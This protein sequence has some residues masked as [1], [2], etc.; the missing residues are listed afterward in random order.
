MISILPAAPAD[1]A[2]LAELLLEMDKFYG[3]SSIESV[4]A[5]I[6]G[7]NSALF[8]DPP[9]AYALLAWQE[10]TL[11][12]FVGYSFL[13]P[14]AL[15]ARSL[16]LKELYVSQAHQRAGVGR[17]LMTRLFEVAAENKCSRV[18]WT[19]DRDNLAAQSF[20]QRLALPVN[21]S[22]LFYRAEGYVLNTLG[23]IGD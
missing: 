10:S 5:K 18:E 1:A 15:S 7:I 22:K 20:Y 13:W 2:P 11:V 16:Y 8:S 19:T 21:P 9:Y 3:E 14:A 12:G 4:E 6:A 23:T 17:L